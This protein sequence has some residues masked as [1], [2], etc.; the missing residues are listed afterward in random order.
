MFWNVYLCNNEK[1]LFVMQ[2]IE[3]LFQSDLN[4]FAFTSKSLDL[5]ISF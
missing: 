2:D 1:Y 3:I 4:H 5:E